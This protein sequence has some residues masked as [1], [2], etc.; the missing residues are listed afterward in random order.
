MSNL[1][2]R[3]ASVLGVLGTLGKGTSRTTFPQPASG[4]TRPAFT[5][6]VQSR[7]GPASSMIISATVNQSQ[8]ERSVDG[9]YQSLLWL[10]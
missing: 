1:A 7:T 4:L 6:A 10:L 8:N 9:A 2:C 5:L 3:R